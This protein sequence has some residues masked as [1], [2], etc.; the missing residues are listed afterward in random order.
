MKFGVRSLK[1]K[2]ER[3]SL[4]SNFTFHSSH[5]FLATI[6]RNFEELGV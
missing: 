6:K 3:L 1:W 2:M 4:L 5:F